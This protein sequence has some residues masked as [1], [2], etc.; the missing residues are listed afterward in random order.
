MDNST[1]VKEER[2]VRKQ[3]L[4]LTF[5]E[6]IGINLGALL[7][8]IAKSYFENVPTK[9]FVEQIASLVIGLIGFGLF[10]KYV[11]KQPGVNLFTLSL[12]M[13]A[14]FIPFIPIVIMGFVIFEG[15]QGGAIT[16]LL[17]LPLCILDFFATL[18][19]RRINKEI[20]ARTSLHAA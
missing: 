11:Y 3:L 9:E 7:Y 16:M 1:L 19:L 6:F 15:F 18:R 13:K 8:Y 17:T 5:F 2:T 10:Y 4:Y 20:Q 12:I 14:L